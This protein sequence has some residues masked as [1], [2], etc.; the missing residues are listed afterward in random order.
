MEGIVDFTVKQKDAFVTIIPLSEKKEGT[1]SKL[2]I[3]FDGLL[4][5]VLGQDGK[6]RENYDFL[7]KYVPIVD[8]LV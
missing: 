3:F 6:L 8:G 1:L 5:V 4:T 2:F 7:G